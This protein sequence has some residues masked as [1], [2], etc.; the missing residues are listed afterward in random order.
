MGQKF[1]NDTA[2]AEFVDCIAVELKLCAVRGFK[3]ELHVIT[4]YRTDIKG[5]DITYCK[6]V[7]DIMPVT[8]L[9]LAE[10]D[11]HAEET[12]NTIMLLLE[13]ADPTTPNW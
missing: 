1:D 9:M 13:N 8:H 3:G 12:L 4:N 11:H 2:C 7:S 10:F 5:K 6:H